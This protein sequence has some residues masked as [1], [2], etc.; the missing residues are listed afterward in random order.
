[1]R[2]RPRASGF[3]H[4][5]ERGPQLDRFVDH[6]VGGRVGCGRRSE[7]LGLGQPA[8]PLGH[9]GHHPAGELLGQP[10]GGLG[11]H[12]TAEL[13][14]AAVDGQVGLHRDLGLA[15]V[16]RGQDAAAAESGHLTGGIQPFDWR[17]VSL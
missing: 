3:G 5:A 2:A 7:R 13:A 11:D 1:M 10:V 12:P 15:G 4:I 9:P 6:G 17:S 8:Q 16:H 14:G